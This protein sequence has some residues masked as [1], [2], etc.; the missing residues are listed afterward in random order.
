MLISIPYVFVNHLLI[1]LKCHS[2]HILYQTD[3]LQNIIL[4]YIERKKDF[5]FNLLHD[6]RCPR[7]FSINMEGSY[8]FFVLTDCKTI[9]K[10]LFLVLYIHCLIYLEGNKEINSV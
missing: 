3:K 4:Y 6:L 2:L 10:A 5:K 8:I 1:H 7:Y 9:T